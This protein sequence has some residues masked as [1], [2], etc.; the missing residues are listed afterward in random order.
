MTIPL[1]ARYPC[2]T[3]AGADR[4]RQR[5]DEA[6]IRD[7]GEVWP[8]GRRRSQASREAFQAARARAAGKS[9]QELRDIYVEEL[10]TRALKVPQEPVLD[11]VIDRI[12]GNPRPAARLAGETPVGIGKQ[13]HG[14]I[15]TFRQP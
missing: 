5:I 15:K 3:C 11:A 6:G 13:I 12:N 10:R 2:C 7:V 14:L 4:E 1:K 9:R 8:E